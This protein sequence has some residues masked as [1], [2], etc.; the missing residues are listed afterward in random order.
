MTRSPL[1]TLTALTFMIGLPFVL[2]CPKKATPDVDAGAASPAVTI[3]AAPTIVAP[4]DTVDAGEDA[5]AA[6]AGKKPTGSGLTT[7][8]QRAKQ[9]CNALRGQAKALGNPPELVPLVASCDAFALQVGPS[10]GG[11]APELEPLRQLLKG[12]PTLPALCSGL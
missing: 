6:D 10:K 8:Q 5:G 12:K 1:R 3:D 2:G 11:Q 4:L 9:C 7:S